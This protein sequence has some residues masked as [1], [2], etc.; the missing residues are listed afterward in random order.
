MCLHPESALI[1]PSTGNWLLSWGTRAFSAAWSDA[2]HSPL[3]TW[4]AMKTSCLTLLWASSF[5]SYKNVPVCSEMQPGVPRSV[6]SANQE[7]GIS[8][9]AALLQH[10]PLQIHQNLCP[11]PSCMSVS[12]KWLWAGPELLQDRAHFKAD[13][14][15]LLCVCRWAQPLPGQALLWAVWEQLLAAANGLATAGVALSASWAHRVCREHLCKAWALSPAQAYLLAMHTMWS[16][17][18]SHSPLA[19][20]SAC[21][22]TVVLGWLDSFWTWGWWVGLLLGWSHSDWVIG[23]LVPSLCFFHISS[24]DNTGFSQMFGDCWKREEGNMIQNFQA[25][26]WK[27]QIV[28]YFGGDVQ[29]G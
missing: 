8:R 1:C 11:G 16:H 2:A 23:I 19:A 22:W 5:S 25:V 18:V 17:S 28:F 3:D 29:P 24:H 21:A 7:L 14:A 13:F 9:A 4:S 12:A 6:C 27:G 15:G 26:L 10:I 20:G